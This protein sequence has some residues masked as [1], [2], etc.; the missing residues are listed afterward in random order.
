VPR[1]HFNHFFTPI[2]FR[3]F[4][5]FH[6]IAASIT[7][8]HVHFILIFQV[9]PIFQWE[10]QDLKMEVRKRT[11]IFGHILLVV[12]LVGTSNQS[13]LEMAIDIFAG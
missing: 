13:V 2:I 5:K 12:C 10:F 4:S 8:F 1:T 9:L 6:E 7:I 3:S 11:I